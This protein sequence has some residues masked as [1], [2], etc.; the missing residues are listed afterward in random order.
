[1]LNLGLNRHI[2]GGNI[3]T[4]GSKKCMA[5]DELHTLIHALNPS[6]KRYI[7]QRATIGKD[8]AEA[9]NARL[10]NCLAKMVTFDK[11]VLRREFDWKDFGTNYASRKKYLYNFILDQLDNYRT[12]QT[13][14]EKV[15][16]KIRHIR[17]L[18]DKGLYQHAYRRIRQAQKM[19]LAKPLRPER[20]ALLEMERY[21][22]ANGKAEAFS[23][24]VLSAK[25]AEVAAVLESLGLLE[26]LTGISQRFLA[27]KNQYG[28]LIDDAQRRLAES[29]IADPALETARSHPEHEIVVLY[30]RIHEL[31]ASLTGDHRE[32]VRWARLSFRH[33]QAHPEAIP[34][35]ESRYLAS[36]HNYINGCML[37]ALYSEGDRLMEIL[38]S[39]KPRTP[40][41]R[42]KHFESLA[43]FELIRAITFQSAAAQDLRPI[44]DGLSALGPKLNQNFR[45]NLY[46][47][48]C[49]N[50]FLREDYQAAIHWV[51]K[52]E[53]EV[54][55]S[56]IEKLRRMGGLFFLLIHYELGNYDLLEY[57][58]RNY[59]Q[60]LKGK[61][62]YA[63]E[64]FFLDFLASLIGMAP[65][66][67]K[68]VFRAF[69][70]ELKELLSR[71]GEVPVL[72][73][74]DFLSW[75]RSKVEGCAV[76]E[77]IWAKNVEIGL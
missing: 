26:H 9:V 18:I 76:R 25:N 30:Y 63:F 34:H 73:F 8:G 50:Y 45:H 15:R 51:R 53:T 31:Y 4:S 65:A 47:L 66:A 42:L 44:V 24:A 27:I 17:L 71:E 74:F 29:L 10:F 35:H 75:A 5:T 62:M 43:G 41:N 14:A 59:G 3:D 49:I 57:R 52:V 33:W 69:E 20:Y 12:D 48:L 36:L 72:S 16:R 54:P 39:H 37:L 64:R 61:E 38:R 19:A 70:V 2:G 67:K 21:L 32:A 28:T 23:D 77:V 58:I 1:M 40:R 55:K 22:I 56:T 46:W 68:E 7:T 60:Y 11:E 6:E 13:V